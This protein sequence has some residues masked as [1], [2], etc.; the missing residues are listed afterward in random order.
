MRGKPQEN[1]RLNRVRKGR[2]Q[3]RGI[4]KTGTN[5]RERGDR[6]DEKYLF[7][8]NGKYYRREMRKG[9]KEGKNKD[10]FV[11]FLGREGNEQKNEPELQKGFSI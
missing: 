5:R 9:A 2:K 4:L 11:S 3:I 10:N 6:E 7:Q 1:E 8:G